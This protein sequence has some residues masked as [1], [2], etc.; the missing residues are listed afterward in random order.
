M[1]VQRKKRFVLIIPDGAGD[2]YRIFGRSP[3]ALAR[4]CCM[5]FIAREGV[6]GIMQTLYSHLPKESIVAQLG[7]LG[8]DPLKYYPCGRASCELLALEDSYLQDDDLAFR[9]N[10]V[11]M[12]GDIL[13][14]YN[15]DYILSEQAIPLIRTL[16]RDLQHEF[17]DFELYHNSDFRN[18]LVVRG[19]GVSPLLLK[20]LE[21]HESH[22]MAFNRES[23]I[24]AVT[25]ESGEIARRINRYLSRAAYLLR[26][27][28]ANTILLW[29]PSRT[30][31]LPSFSEHIGFE[32]KVGVVGSMDFLH[33]IA[34]AGGLEFFKVGNGRPDTDYQGKGEKVVELLKDGYEFITCHINAPDEASHMQDLEMKIKSLEWIDYFIVRPVVE[35]FQSN[36]DELGGVMIVPD[37]YTNNTGGSN[38][39]KRLEGHS[40]HPVPFALW[41]GRERDSVRYYSEDEALDGKYAQAAVGHLDLLRLLG[42]QL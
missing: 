16:N 5:D 2:K 3:L 8:W 31:R 35:Y 27:Q 28:A 17:S 14:S 12:E 19:A 20:C 21:P 40:A 6:T 24:S 37:H 25:E 34:K 26:D 10:L 23:L 42:V 29:S 39:K 18:T 22:G 9:A 38:H 7:M 1:A 36:L 41:N 32:G 11:R 33:G 4:T 30:L 15:A 13:A